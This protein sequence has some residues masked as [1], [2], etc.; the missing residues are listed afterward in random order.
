MVQYRRQKYILFFSTAMS[1]CARTNVHV[2]KHKGRTI[3][4]GCASYWTT[5]HVT[6]PQPL[7]PQRA[8]RAQ[9]MH[10]TAFQIPHSEIS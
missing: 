7:Q 1:C 8:E 2:C 4:K 9:Q 5:E 6:L 3:K 10:C